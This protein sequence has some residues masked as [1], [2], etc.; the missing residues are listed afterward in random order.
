MKQKAFFALLVLLFCSFQA[1]SAEKEGAI[2][3]FGKSCADL[4]HRSMMVAPYR[5]I[6]DSPMVE[7]LTV[8]VFPDELYQ[9]EFAARVGKLLSEGK[10]EDDSLNHGTWIIQ[11]TRANISELISSHD[12]ASIQVLSIILTNGMILTQDF[13]NSTSRQVHLALFDPFFWQMPNQFFVDYSGSD[14]DSMLL[15]AV[16]FRQMG[17]KVDISKG[18]YALIDVPQR[19]LMTLIQYFQIHQSSVS[20]AYQDEVEQLA[21]KYQVSVDHLAK[22][23][24]LDPNTVLK[25]LNGQHLEPPASR[26]FSEDLYFKLR[27][28]INKTSALMSKKE[29]GVIQIS[30]ASMHEY[31]VAYQALRRMKIDVLLVSEQAFGI[32]M[33]KYNFKALLAVASAAQV[34][35]ITELSEADEVQ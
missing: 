15:D 11:G 28:G 30:F 24:Q 9:K 25:E 35:W 7:K 26:T 21:K 22:A 13:L 4:M 33:R 32:D 2:T 6:L 12:V 10:G 1:H 8:Q 16:T 29:K 20:I 5:Y 34:E 27:E 31:R 17:M 14:E 19:A 23:M 18:E 3:R